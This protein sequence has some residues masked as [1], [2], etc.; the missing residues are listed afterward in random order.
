MKVIFFGLGSIGQK[1]LRILSENFDWDI[2]AYRTRNLAGVLP[3]K[4]NLWDWDSVDFIK[5][6]VAIIT[7]PTHLHIETAI[8]CA[9][10]GMHL[11]ITKPLDCGLDFSLTHLKNVVTA[12]KLT[13]CL[14]Y[15]LRHLPVVKKLKA[16]SFDHSTLKFV[17]H[18]DLSK[19][20]DYKTYS[21]KYDE[22]GGVLLE[23]SHEL[24]LATY[25]LGDVLKMRGYTFDLGSETDAEDVANVTLFHKGG[26]ISYHSLSLI[27]NVEER[28]IQIGGDRHEIVPNDQDIMY[29]NMFKYFFDNIGNVDIDNNLSEA[30]RLYEVLWEFR[31]ETHNN[32]MRTGR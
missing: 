29:I 13:A 16:E 17:C 15:P 22:G 12:K 8:R 27:S 21:A 1:Y 28:Y 5:P 32:N 2:F 31:D 26:N 6:D 19:W 24:D 10:R 14:A 11:L 7:N 4:Q 23:L 25:L 30:S 9:E 18:T 20:R 3:I